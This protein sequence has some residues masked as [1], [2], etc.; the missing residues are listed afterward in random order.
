MDFKSIQG[1]Y[2]GTTKASQ[3]K[4]DVHHIIIVIH[5]KYKFYEI[6]F[7]GYLVMASDGRTGGHTEYL[8]DLRAQT[9]AVM[10]TF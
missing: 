8:L 2:S 3:T 1:L 4:L 10:L 6:P 5:I 7:I 9:H